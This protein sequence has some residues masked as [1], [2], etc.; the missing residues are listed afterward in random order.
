MHVHTYFDAFSSK[1]QFNSH[2]GEFAHRV[3]AVDRSVDLN[4]N[5]DEKKNRF[6]WVRT[7]K[8]I[9]LFRITEKVSVKNLS[10]WIINHLCNLRLSEANRED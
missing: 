2:E 9:D 4:H 8:L 6:Q 1:L 5:W 3:R 7:S 10:D